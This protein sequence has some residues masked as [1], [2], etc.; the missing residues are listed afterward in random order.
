MVYEKIP[1]LVR[2]ADTLT[3]SG[4]SFGNYV[5]SIVNKPFGTAGKIKTINQNYSR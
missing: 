4:N 2:E 3:A 1:S 5:G